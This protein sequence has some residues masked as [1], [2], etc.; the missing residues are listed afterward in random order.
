MDNDTT[1]PK[2]CCKCKE[3]YPPTTE[4]F[5]TDGKYLRSK[6]RSCE[7]LAAKDYYYDNR[8]DVL[9]QKRLDRIARPE[10]YAERDLLRYLIDPE[11]EKA[12]WKRYRD[13]HPEERRATMKRWRD[14]NPLKIKAYSKTYYIEHRESEKA[15]ARIEYRRKR[16]YYLLLGCKASIKRRAVLQNTE[17]EFHPADI[18]Q[19]FIEQQGHCMYCGCELTR[20]I[21]RSV[22]IDHII[23]ISRGGSNWPNNLA[24]ACQSCNLSKADKLLS[25]WIAVRGW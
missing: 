21:P 16:Q 23:P 1:Q 8:D 2:Q 22:H 9:E 4:H 12:R 14:N 3:L 18:E 13:D 24:L 6:C 19:I 11:K 17:G 15:Q 25:E 10:V 20:H 7:R 5:R